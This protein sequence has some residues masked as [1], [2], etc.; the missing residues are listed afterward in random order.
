MSEHTASSIENMRPALSDEVVQY[1]ENSLVFRRL[2]T[3]FAEMESEEYGPSTD[4]A[5]ALLR[6]I[7][8]SDA[9]NPDGQSV[10][11]LRRTA[12]LSCI[13]LSRNF[14][15]SA[16]AMMNLAGQEPTLLTSAEW[17]ALVERTVWRTDIPV[18]IQT[19]LRELVSLALSELDMTTE[20]KRA[21]DFTQPEHFART[22]ALLE[23]LG[24]TY[25]TL[26]AVHH[27]QSDKMGELRA[28]FEQV[29]AKQQGSYFLNT[30]AATLLAH[31]QAEGPVATDNDR[32]PFTLASGME[33]CW[34]D[35]QLLER[36]IG[37]E[38]QFRPVTY[39]TRVPQDESVQRRLSDY[40]ALM[41]KP[42]RER[43]ESDLGVSITS[44]PKE[45]QVFFLEYIKT[46]EAA[47]V[48]DV[49][50][51]CQT[52]GIDGVRAFL[53]LEQ[54]RAAMS[55]AI[56][57]IATE[58]NVNDAKK[59]FAKYSKLVDTAR[60]AKQYVAEQLK[61]VDDTVVTEVEQALLVRGKTLLEQAAA[62]A[63]N[64][65]EWIQQLDAVVER[66]E[67]LRAVIKAEHL[68]GDVERLTLLK[69]IELREYS[70]PA[71]LG[72][73]ALCQRLEKLYDQNHKQRGKEFVDAVVSR[74]KERLQDPGAVL[75]LLSYTE[76][77]EA[78]L[79][80][81]CNPDG[82]IELSALN[83]D[84]DFAFAKAGFGL[85][86]YVIRKCEVTGKSVVFDCP[87]RLAP[88]YQRHGCVPVGTMELGGQTLVL[89]RKDPA[90]QNP[91]S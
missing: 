60:D 90:Q 35:G 3:A 36:T 75:Y 51:L 27:I 56:V 16:S 20:L 29:V 74:F 39:Q 81:H 38:D 63:D 70:G 67:V 76:A 48:Q 2:A 31:M 86:E 82:T 52:F 57:R 78:Y 71:I 87:E 15:Q 83:T 65:T 54:G 72:D 80:E 14:P 4:E 53:S 42:M 18:E 61:E 9:N 77:P 26:D 7:L 12:F 44:L 40:A 10:E 49:R 46:I 24:Q 85:F 59:I 33:G 91:Q 66:A 68:A 62:S 22:S 30:R 8:D 47:A 84:P 79:L 5:A 23:F 45:E 41:R 55:V 6:E 89:M 19:R 1:T 11:D 13:E 28:M 88:A 25:N 34:Q 37:S 21:L 50:A 17:V 73:I 64:P 58:Y 32:A 43:I 69:D